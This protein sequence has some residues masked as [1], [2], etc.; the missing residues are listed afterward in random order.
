MRRQQIIISIIA[1]LAILGIYQL[2]KVV[3]KNDE[4]TTLSQEQTP[5]ESQIH[6]MDIPDSVAIK[7]DQFRDILS[8][9]NSMQ[10]S[11]T[12]ADSLARAFL[13]YNQ[14]D[15]AAKY[16]EYILQLDTVGLQEVAG[17]IYYRAFGLVNDR[18]IAE[19]FGER[20][21]AVY[22]QVSSEVER[23]DL[24]ARIAMTQVTGDNPM[25]GILKLR[26]LAEENPE[27]IEAQYNLGLLSIQSGQFDRAVD[28]FTTVTELD[29]TNIE[30]YFYLGVS[31]LEIGNDKKAKENFIYV[32]KEGNDPAIIKLVEDYLNKIN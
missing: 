5:E 30:G 6:E 8:R 18:I 4:E 9:S 17:N 23:P 31:Y 20:V 22:S 13:I 10:K 26:E 19:R 16:A 28:R 14:I 11:S 12:F 27:N 24:A 32:A 1:A 25:K 15:S 21:R 7:I 2:P 29:P 3:V